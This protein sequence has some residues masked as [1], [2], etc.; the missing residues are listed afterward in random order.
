MK[1]L[2]D[3]GFKVVLDILYRITDLLYIVYLPV[4]HGTRLMLPVTLG[5]NVK[6]IIGTI[7]D[8]SDNTPC[9]YIQSEYKLTGIL[10]TVSHFYTSL[11][12]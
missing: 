3:Y 4:K 8:R 5:H 1:L 10:L 11:I 9:S 2:A 6:S 7:S 12:L